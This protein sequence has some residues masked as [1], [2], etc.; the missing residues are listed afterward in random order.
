[1]SNAEF[2]RFARDYRDIHQANIGITGEAPEYF[3]DY[4]MRDFCAVVQAA[5]APADGRYLDF[6]S[7]I[8]ASVLPFRRHLP[9]AR[10]MCADVSGES[11]E[12][13]QKNHGASVDYLLVE[14][15]RLPLP[16]AGIDGAFACCVFHH[17]PSEAHGEALREIR[18]VLRIDAP[19]MLYEHNPYNPLTRHAVN[20][21]PV[22]ENAVLIRPAEMARRCRAAGFRDVRV[23]YRVFF[24]AALKAL[25]PLESHLRWLP[26]GAQYA[27]HCVA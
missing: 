24:P 19:L 20:T 1:M 5:G 2:D 9:Q 25:R 18:R 26:T 23:Q 16:D 3:A 7:G 12:E 8:G 10:L 4:K 27:V 22:D 6:G 11:L 14:D 17:I 15:G 13:S 21:C